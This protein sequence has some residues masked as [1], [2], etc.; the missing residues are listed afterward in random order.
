MKKA[1]LAVILVILIG[2]NIFVLTAMHNGYDLNDLFMFDGSKSLSGR[3]LT[4]NDVSSAIPQPIAVS[5]S[6][7]TDS[8]SEETDMSADKLSVTLASVGE[9]TDYSSYKIGDDIGNYAANIY[10]GGNIVKYNSKLYYTDIHNSNYLYFSRSDYSLYSKLNKVHSTCINVCNDRIYYI[11]N[12][13]MTINSVNLSNENHKKLSDNPATCFIVAGDYLYYVLPK[14]ENSQCGELHR[15]DKDGK[16]DVRLS[17][18]GY[19]CENIIPCGDY[20]LFVNVSDG[21]KS[22]CVLDIPNAKVTELYSGDVSDINYCDSVLWFVRHS[23]ESDEICKVDVDS[24]EIK[25]I[26]QIE[27]IDNMIVSGEY[28]YYIAGRD[29]ESQCCRLSADGTKT[30]I[31]YDNEQAFIESFNVMDNCVY[32][33][34]SGENKLHCLTPVDTAV[35]IMPGLKK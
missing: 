33:S 23:D 9:L 17:S 31:I 3:S 28:V 18:E 6:E 19:I 12:N 16:N 22:I 26:T 1:F 24:D 11:D 30:E 25:V 4:E 29:N 13:D 8:I 2:C 32:F 21:G 5:P 14:G 34:A 15:M 20:V 10:N 27:K 35:T 7:Q